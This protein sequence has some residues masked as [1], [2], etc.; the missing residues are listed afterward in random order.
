LAEF[1]KENGFTTAVFE[2]F[3]DGKEPWSSTRARNYIESGQVDKAA[4]VLGRFPRLEGLV[5][6]GD[7]RGREL[8]YP[9]A[10]LETP[11]LMSVPE[12]GIYAGY[13]VRSKTNEVLPA[14]I[15]IG[16][17]PTFDG[18][19]KRVE[20][21]ALDRTDLDLYGEQVSFDFV[22]QIR[23]TVKFDSVDALVSQMARD[24]E[25]TRRLTSH[26]Y[27]G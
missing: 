6:H 17:N 11:V 18:K 1:G 22:K 23:K 10:N 8:G 12:D 25:E 20:A 2:R 3:S 27:N 15:S 4:L 19:E 14:A 24:V 13:L 9:T 5:V 16:T 26:T 21:Y 7:H